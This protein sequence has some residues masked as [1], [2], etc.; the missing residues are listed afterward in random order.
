MAGFSAKSLID[1]LKNNKGDNNLPKA[2]LIIDD[3]D[4]Y[5]INRRG[6]W[7]FEIE[8][9]LIFYPM[10][11]YIPQAD[12]RT[13]AEISSEILDKYEMIVDIS[14]YKNKSFCDLIKENIINGKK[15]LAFDPMSGYVEYDIIGIFGLKGSQFNINGNIPS[16]N[17]SLFAR[18]D[19]NDLIIN[20]NSNCKLSIELNS[21]QVPIVIKTKNSILINSYDLNEKTL[22]IAFENFYGY[23][24]N[25]TILYGEGMESHRIEF[26]LDGELLVEYKFN[27]PAV[28]GEFE[29]KAI[30][31]MRI[32][33]KG[34]DEKY[35]K[36]IF[37]IL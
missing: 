21:R 29:C 14:V 5:W 2:L 10:R 30:H 36:Q 24:M 31:E 1:A 15:I 12:V 19:I 23:K 18:D 37:G 32:L 13:I 20:N 11:R 3:L 16:G 25:T 28:I 33:P 34:I 4:E 6:D 26:E 9:Q 17:I 35:Y 27:R 7:H 22:K 8:R